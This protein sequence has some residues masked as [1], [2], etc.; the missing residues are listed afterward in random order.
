[1]NKAMALLVVAILL[2][3]LVYMYQAPAPD[4]ASNGAEPGATAADPPSR[5]PAATQA[6]RGVLDISVHS[7]EELKVLFD[8]AEEF[9]QRPRPVGGQD[10]IVLVLHGPEVEFFAIPN[11]EEYRDIVDRAARLDAFEV[12]D[13]R[14]C[15]TMMENY[16][17]GPDDIPAFIEQV[18]DGAAEVERLTREGYTY[19]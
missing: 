11:Y 5:P 1:M 6:T 16:G 19:F 14:I 9:A 17:L 3:V 13:V 4:A 2:G 8:R 15:R 12:V 7:I 10:S 18:P